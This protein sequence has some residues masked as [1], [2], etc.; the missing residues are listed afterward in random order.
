M[1]LLLASC[2]ALSL[3]A[4]PPPDA[5]DCV[6]CHDT[7]DLDAFRTR[8]HGGLTCV[9]CH[10]AIK[11]LPHAEKLPP[12]Q[13]VT[14]HNHQGQ[15]Y[16]ESVHGIAR[17]AGKEHAPTCMTCH[18]HA[19]D[20]LPKNDPASRVA[21]KNMAATCGKC[22]DQKHLDRLATHLPRRAPVMDIKKLP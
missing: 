14:C 2:F 10:A 1:R 12:P 21:R 5:Q 20:V 19:H 16:A 13:C 15:E 3:A 8:T 6:A 17:K 22:H 7:M 11:Q 9:T 18:G 4:A